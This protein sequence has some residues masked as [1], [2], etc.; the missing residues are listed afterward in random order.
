[1]FGKWSETS[2]SINSGKSVNIA[3]IKLDGGLTGEQLTTAAGVVER[4]RELVSLAKVKIGG[5]WD[6]AMKAAGAKCFSLAPGGPG[7]ADLEM[8]GLVLRKTN[9]GISGT[10]TIKVGSSPDANGYVNVHN[11]FMHKVFSSHAVKNLKTGKKEY[12]GGAHIDREYI[13]NPTQN[14]GFQRGVLTFIHEATHRYAGTVDYDDEGY[15]SA[16]QFFGGG[17]IHFRDEN[18]DGSCKLTKTQLL[19]NADSYAVFIYE[20]ASA[21]VI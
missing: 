16:T 14:N 21:T 4:A 13:V 12:I 15:I 9:S 6:S 5:N 17:G 2:K 3:H 18:P 19:T 11:D 20:I 8:M 10:T 7:N 1:M